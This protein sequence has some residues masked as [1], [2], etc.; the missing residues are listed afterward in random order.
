LLLVAGAKEDDVVGL[1]FG[2]DE[3]LDVMVE[4]KM[5]GIGIVGN[6]KKRYDQQKRVELRNHSIKCKDAGGILP[7]FV[8]FQKLIQCSRN[9]NLC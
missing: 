7:R 9:Q 4:G 3:G 5:V 2:E 1:E 6:T 8:G